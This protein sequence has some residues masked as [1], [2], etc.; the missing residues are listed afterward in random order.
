MALQVEPALGPSS[1]PFG[2]LE[3]PFDQVDAMDAQRLAGAE[4]RRD[5]VAMVDGFQRAAHVAEPLREDGR[6]PFEP[7]HGEGI[8]RSVRA[9]AP[10]RRYKRPAAGEDHVELTGKQRRALRAMAHHLKPVVQVGVGGVSP[11]VIAKVGE[12]LENHELIKVR[13]GREAPDDAD[14]TAELLAQA[15]GAHLAQII[16]RTVLLY[17]ARKDEP[18]I[19]L[20]D[21]ASEGSG[22]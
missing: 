21:Q 8:T 11:A 16:G 5:V 12:E 15:T 17:R 4:D 22:K 7:V 3:L 1:C 10:G 9:S 14:A 2:G 18:T 20:P 6:H 19:R 13:V